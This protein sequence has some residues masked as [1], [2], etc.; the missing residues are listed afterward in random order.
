MAS[1]DGHLRPQLDAYYNHYEN[2][3]VTIGYPAFPTFGIELN[4]PNPTEIYGLEAQAEA[5]FG[6]LSFDAGLGLMHSQLGVFYAVDPRIPSV[7]AC[8]PATGPASSSCINLDGREQTYAPDFTF[9]I[10]GQYIFDLSGSDTPH[11]APQLWPRV[12]SV[13]DAVR[14]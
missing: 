13:G 7:G 3:Q 9:N 1:F 11:P 8:A 6:P 10:G 4:T 14:R 2:F 12:A 5:V